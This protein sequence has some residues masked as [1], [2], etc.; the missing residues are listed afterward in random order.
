MNYFESDLKGRRHATD[1][2][3]MGWTRS[4]VA[5]Y[6][7]AD[8]R[9]AGM[10]WARSSAAHM[11]TPKSC[12]ST[13]VPPRRLPGRSKPVVTAANFPEITSEEAFVGEGPM[14]FRDLSRNIHGTRQGTV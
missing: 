13:P 14:N 1:S 12:R 4:S 6:S 11:R 9:A 8:T 7:A 2:V 5:L 10:L 3:R